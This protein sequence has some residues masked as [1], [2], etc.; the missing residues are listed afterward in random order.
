[1]D[2]NDFLEGLLS[3][4]EFAELVGMTIATLRFYDKKGL[5]LP[6][7]R[8]VEFE[9][10]YRYYA[11]PQI[12]TAKLVRVL[13]EIGVPLDTI[14]DLAQS[15]TPEKVLKVLSTNR[16]KVADEI[17][18]LQDV[19][20]VVSTFI[21][22]IHEGIDITETD[23][24]LKELPEKRIILGDEN[25]FTEPGVFMGEF[26]RFLKSVHEPGLNASFPVGAYWPDMKSFA[27]DPVSPTRFFSL[28]PKGNECRA[29]GLYLTGYS[30]GYYGHINDLT[31]RMK[32][33]AQKNGLRFTGKVYGTY[34]FDE[35]SIVDPEQYLLQVCA[36]VTETRRVPSRRPLSPR[37]RFLR[38]GVN[39]ITFRQEKN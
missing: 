2:I 16:D 24:T 1:L 19:L 26:I 39:N 12:I 20:A 35:I 6:A 27:Q 29:A 21:D 36:A 11:A 30:R 4:K 23:I 31:G 28:D 18:F 38:V 8:G 10:N 3:T 34:V 7:K 25:H 14:K 33:F 13:T 9:N 22:L 32:N 37:R 5:L 15:R 17:R